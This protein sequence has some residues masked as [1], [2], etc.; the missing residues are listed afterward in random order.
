MVKY[1]KLEYTN[2]VKSLFNYVNNSKNY[3]LD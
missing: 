2:Q 1:D 3:V